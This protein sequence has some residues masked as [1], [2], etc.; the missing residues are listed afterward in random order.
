MFT[1]HAPHRRSTMHTATPGFIT[2][3]PPVDTV[4]LNAEFVCASF[5]CAGR[6][7]AL[8]AG[9]AS[10]V[11][12]AVAAQCACVQDEWAELTGSGEPLAAVLRAERECAARIQSHFRNRA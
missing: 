12:Q 11:A 3:C 4:C 5:L 7:S 9:G 8:A 1:E 6:I 10:T 2:A